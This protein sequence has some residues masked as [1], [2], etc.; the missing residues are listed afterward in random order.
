MSL[1]YTQ[2]AR[3]LIVTLATEDPDDQGVFRKR[4]RVLAIQ[5]AAAFTVET[6]RGV[7]SGIAGD[8]LVTNHPDDD[9][10]SDIWTIS[11]ERMRATYERTK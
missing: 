9:P 2:A 4:A 3:D 7:M 11:D 1:H 5:L 6:D 8:W 10:G